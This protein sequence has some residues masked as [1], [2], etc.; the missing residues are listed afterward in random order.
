MYNDEF[1]S[2][3]LLLVYLPTTKSDTLFLIYN[4]ILDTR[5]SYQ[6][7]GKRRSTLMIRED[8]YKPSY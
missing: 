1:V 8:D 6:S 3:W 5:T 4:I 7:L 2:N